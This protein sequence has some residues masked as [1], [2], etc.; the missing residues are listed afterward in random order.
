MHR[1]LTQRDYMAAHAQLWIATV[2]CMYSPRSSSARLR[3]N[4][5]R[6]WVLDGLTGADAHAASVGPILVRPRQ[7][8]S[9]MRGPMTRNDILKPLE[10]DEAWPRPFG[11]RLR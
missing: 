11:L 2:H 7:T 9:L 10:W 8:M 3:T 5:D 4:A 1:T 6:A